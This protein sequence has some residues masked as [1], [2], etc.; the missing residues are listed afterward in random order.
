MRARGKRRLLMTFIALGCGAAVAACGSAGTPTGTSGN[1]SANNPKLLSF[2]NCV[3]SHGVPNLPDPGSRPSDAGSG[4]APVITFMGI[5]FPPG[6]TPRSPAFR[7]AMAS[8]RHLLPNGGVPHAVSAQERKQLLA[9]A[10]CMRTHGVPK[11]PDPVFP[12]QGGIAIRLGGV[13]I[14]PQSPAFQRASRICARF[15]FP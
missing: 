3:R 1:G 2:V 12:A 14:N 9:G 10:Q 6:L 5:A 4:S 13:G 8:C 15:K 7:S 11:F